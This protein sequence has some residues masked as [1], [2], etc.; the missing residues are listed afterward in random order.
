VIDARLSPGTLLELQVAKPAVGGR[1]LARAGGEVVLVSGAIPGERVMARID[2]RQQGVWFATTVDVLDASADRVDA[3]PDPA[4]G[5]MS[6]A[7]VA[8]PRQCELKAQIVTDALARIGKVSLDAPVPFTPSL[9]R[10]YRM[11]FR[12]HAPQQGGRLGFYREGTHTVC[13]PRP[14]GQLADESLAFVEGLA[15]RLAPD[16]LGAVHAIECIENLPNTQRALNLVVRDGRQPPDAAVSAIASAPGLCGASWSCLH[17]PDVA[18]L[19]GEPWVSDPLTSIT[20]DVSA[21]ARPAAWLAG[22]TIRRHAAAFFQANRFL[23]PFLAGRV[24][25]VVGTRPAVDLYAGVGLFAMSLVARGAER[26]TAIESDRVSGRDLETNAAPLGRRVRVVRT[27]VEDFFRTLPSLAGHA[28]V[29][30]PPR[31]G[32]SR[33]ATQGVL[34][35]GAQ[36]LVYV[37][38]DVATLARD[39]RR[40]LD[41]GYALQSIEALDLFPNTA[42]LEAI[43]VFDRIRD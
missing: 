33:A 27:T 30:D 26:V 22:V 40:I 39:T 23:T 7:H 16:V 10:G 21:E 41:S 1:M 9:T 12:V 37:S 20:A 6:F 38:C 5:G 32:M 8:Y 36:R 31:T 3:G 25:E 24:C 42:H 28:I 18:T 11:R 13:D 35:A 29:V 2:R 4:C 15:A 34:M 43:A 14:S 17:R 19:A